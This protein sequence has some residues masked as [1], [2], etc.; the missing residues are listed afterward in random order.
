[1]KDKSRRRLLASTLLSIISR[2]SSFVSNKKQV[3]LLI[4][5]GENVYIPYRDSL[6]TLVLRDSL[7]GN[8][9]TRMI[10]TVSVE[11][12]NVDETIS[13]LKFA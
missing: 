3:P 8:C 2:E 9:M 13:T 5:D 6:M 12:K 7:G 1:L 10:A 4:L 11:N